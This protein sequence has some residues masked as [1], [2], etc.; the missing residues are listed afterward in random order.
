[1]NNENLI[2]EWQGILKQKYGKDIPKQNILNCILMISKKYNLD[3]E[4]S[5]IV[6][7]K[8]IGG[9]RKKTERGHLQNFD[10]SCYMDCILFVLLAIPNKF[11]ETEILNKKCSSPILKQIQKELNDLKINILNGNQ[12]KCVN[13]RQLLG[14]YCINN[15]EDFSSMHA[16]DADEFL[17]Y[18]FRIF[19][20]ENSHYRQ[21][22]Y[23]TNKLEGKITNENV[24]LTSKTDNMKASPVFD[25]DTQI[26]KKTH[27][28]EMLSNIV[29]APD[30]SGAFDN[31]NLFVANGKTFK[32]RIEILQPYDY[33]YLI[34]TLQRLNP[35]GPFINT[36]IIPDDKLIL[37]NG[38]H[39]KLNSIV[40]WVKG[41]YVAMVQ[42]ENKWWLYNDL[43]TKLIIIGSYKQMIKCCN[44]IAMTN[45]ILYFYV[46]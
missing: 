35:T 8:L 36:Q 15:F 27:S 5:I 29:K 25:I 7:D 17:K 33:S 3:I 46:K 18:L 1:M 22:T 24:S 10:N 43:D 2:E 32:R 4:H 39:L 12:I 41:H 42:Y 16:Q 37:G 19:N 38:N 40:I 30:D 14:K 26:L 6:I 28:N 21:F 31:T 13:F 34:V 20:V 9:E 44:G 45:G 11:I 23:G